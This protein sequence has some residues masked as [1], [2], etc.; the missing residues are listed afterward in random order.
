MAMETVE[1]IGNDYGMNTTTG[2]EGES[3]IE[4]PQSPSRSEGTAKRAPELNAPVTEKKYT[5]IAFAVLGLLVVVASGILIWHFSSGHKSNPHHQL[6][7]EEVYL[8]GTEEISAANTMKTVED[9]LNQGWGEGE[10]NSVELDVSGVFES[11]KS[12]AERI[13][14]VL[15]EFMNK[16]LEICDYSSTKTGGHSGTNP[17]GPGKQGSG[18]RPEHN[19]SGP[20]H[21]RP[22]HNGSGPH[23]HRPGHNGSGPHHHRPGHNGSGP[24]HHRPGHNGSGPHHQRPRHHGDDREDVLDTTFDP[25]GLGRRTLRKDFG[26]PDWKEGL[27]TSEGFDIEAVKE[28]L[29][30]K[31]GVDVAE[32]TQELI[33]QFLEKFENNDDGKDRRSAPTNL[34]KREWQQGFDPMGTR[35]GETMDKDHNRNNEDFWGRH[36]ASHPGERHHGKPGHHGKHPGHRGSGPRPTFDPKPDHGKH[37]GHRGSGPKHHGKPHHGSGMRPHP[38]PTSGPKPGYGSVSDSITEE[39]FE[40]VG[41]ICGTT[42]EIRLTISES[43]GIEGSFEFNG[44]EYEVNRQGKHSSGIR[45]KRNQNENQRDASGKGHE[46]KRHG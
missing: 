9:A 29:S 7:N 8:R 6:P 34:D 42:E 4:A 20:H 44:R 1:T 38:R 28:M 46:S 19:G 36:S 33:D 14:L 21:H 41:K 31:M 17:F 43:N 27:Q 16:Q 39:V 3:D 35:F 25:I 30:E 11:F 5:R 45:S 32:I 37:P 13:P 40:I 12:N 26:L 22:G 24:H 10:A 2:F 23:H 18:M 15:P